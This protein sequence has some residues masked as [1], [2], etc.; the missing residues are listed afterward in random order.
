MQ[1]EI[2]NDE[3]RWFRE[4]VAT[5]VARE[6]MPARE[7]CRAQRAIDRELWLKAGG[8][9]FLGL[10][11][12]DRY[13][14]ADTD[15]FRFNAIWGEE[16]AKAG[17]AFASS[18]GIQTDVVAPYLLELTTEEQKERWLPG[19]SQGELI[20]AIGMTEPEVG[21]DLARLRSTATLDGDAWILNG[22]KTFITNG[23]N[24]DLIIVAAR[25]GDRNGRGITLLVV[26]A[27]MEGFSRGRKLDKIG[28]HE[29]DTAELFFEDV[30]V[31]AS[32]L[33]G[34]AGQGFSYMMHRLPQERLS[35]ACVNVAHA[36]HA[37]ELT[38][39]YATQRRA[40][41][42]TIGS[43]QHNRFVLAELVTSIDVAQCYVDRCLARHVAGTLTPVEAAKAKLW[44]SEVQNRVIDACVQLHGG[45]GYMEEYDV[46]RAWADA[47][48]SK[49]WGGTNE[50]M[51]EVIGRSLQ[52]D[53][54]EENLAERHE[55][56]RKR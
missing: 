52:L 2:F 5:F 41:G 38:L 4:S 49:I 43:F 18:F 47:R 50:I 24:A 56:G 51:K 27:E 3:H 32:H 14:G 45:Y 25:S 7:R 35:G 39:R 20:A 19:F 46:A 21:S 40:F 10:G 33:L 22:S 23:F 11:V 30:R 9:G 15:D 36:A 28:Q 53:G 54:A 17:M 8:A 16:L 55:I 42:Q 37:L 1:R 34:E 29:A 13:G 31:P 44:T 48:V 26:E 12:P 6:L